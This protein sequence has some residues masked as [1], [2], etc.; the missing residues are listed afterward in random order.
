MYS[1]VKPVLPA[2]KSPFTM[3]FALAYWHPNRKLT[4]KART[5]FAVRGMEVAPKSG[6]GKGPG[7][8]TLRDGRPTLVHR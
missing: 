5:V 7:P 4:A 6:D 1:V 3:K 2:E 8:R